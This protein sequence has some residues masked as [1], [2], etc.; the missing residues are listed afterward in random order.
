MLH[1]LALL[2][3][4]VTLSSEISRYFMILDVDYAIARVSKVPKGMLNVRSER[5]HGNVPTDILD[6][7]VLP[8]AVQKFMI[9]NQ[10][11][12]QKQS[13]CGAGPKKWS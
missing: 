1:M 12:W 2:Y 4:E 9:V 8:I 11:R 6:M 5:H 13:P 7:R 3:E 10:K